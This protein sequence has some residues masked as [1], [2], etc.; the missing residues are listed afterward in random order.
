MLTLAA[1]TTGV[2]LRFVY[3]LGAVRGKIGLVGDSLT[4]HRLGDLLAGG[5]GYIRPVE[6]FN[7]GVSV[8]TAEFP[9]AYPVFLAVLDLVGVDQP[10][11][12]RLAGGLLG[13]VT[14]VV[15]GLLGTAVAGRTVGVVAAWIAAVY[16]QLVVFDGSLLSEGPYALVVATVLLCVVRARATVDTERLRW[17]AAAGAATG[18][19]VMTRSEAILLVPLLLVPATRVPGDGR[20]WTRAA[21]V[22]SAG[23]IVLVGAW[24]V[25]NAIVLDHLQPLTNNS[26]TML[27]GANCDAVY[28]GV[29]I[30]GWRIDCVRPTVPGMDETSS[31]AA[32]RAAGLDYMQAHADE[33]PRV[34]AARVARTFGAWDVRTNLYIESLEGRQFDWLWAAWTGWAILAPLAVVGAVA[35]RRAERALWPLLVPFA[36]AVLTSVAAYGTQRFRMVAEPSTVVLAAAGIVAVVTAVVPAVATRRTDVAGGEPAPPATSGRVPGQEQAPGGSS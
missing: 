4:Y 31:A 7:D 36:I 3:V 19:A 18:L 33:V 10:T 15:I 9:P 11:G 28:S 13:G 6:F 20:A 1:A 35:Q 21:L 32:R 17:W 24:T 12:Q 22:A 23:S 34:M 5:H 30:G 25:R 29:Q 8:P 2:A 16:P 14:I 27:A 26:G